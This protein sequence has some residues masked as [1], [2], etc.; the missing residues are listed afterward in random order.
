[1]G[2]VKIGLGCASMI[3]V[4]AVAVNIVLWTSNHL[5]L[6]AGLWIGVSLGG[7]VAWIVSGVWSGL[8][9]KSGAEIGSRNVQAETGVETAKMRSMVEMWK[10]LQRAAKH[11]PAFPQIETPTV[12]QLT[13]SDKGKQIDL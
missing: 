6:M 8:L 9:I 12:Y 2:K 4:G 5:E 13:E 3:V 1:M 11:E 10:A 7:A